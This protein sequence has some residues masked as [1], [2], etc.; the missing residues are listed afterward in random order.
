[1]SLRHPLRQP[2]RPRLCRRHH[3]HDVRPELSHQRAHIANLSAP[4]SAILKN[5]GQLPRSDRA[6][7]ANSVSKRRTAITSRRTMLRR[8]RRPAGREA[9]RCRQ[10]ITG[11]RNAQM[12]VFAPTGTIG[13]M[14]DC[15]T[16][17]DRARP[18]P[19][20]VQEAGR[21]RR[22]QDRQQH[23]ARRRSSN[24]ATRP[25]KPKQI[26]A[27]IDSTGTIEGAPALKPE[28]LAVFDCSFRPQN[29]TRFHPLTWAI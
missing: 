25:S 7:T 8:R 20:Q 15:D 16:T 12:T 14:M 13:F 9:S 6:C 27:H 29:G 17:G 24:S 23:R 26:V 4:S 10:A 3:R 11:Y 2:R 19:G 22:H 5:E 28:H 21:R 1:M 18:R